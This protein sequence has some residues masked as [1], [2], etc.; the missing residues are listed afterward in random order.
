MKKDSLGWPIDDS[1]PS[2]TIAVNV[3]AMALKGQALKRLFAI[4][5]NLW[6]P[7]KGSD[8]KKLPLGYKEETDELH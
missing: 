2:G 1:Q 4:S 6:K 7:L 3:P 8:R 5:Y